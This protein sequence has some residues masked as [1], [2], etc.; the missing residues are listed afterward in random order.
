MK[1]DLGSNRRLITRIKV[2]EEKVNELKKKLITYAELIQ[3]MVERSI[4]G[5]SDKN[6]ALLKQVIE[7]DEQRA[8]EHEIE[9]DEMCTTLIVT[10]QP[11]A[12][13]L[14]TILMI[15]KMNNDLERIGD[16]AVNISQSALRLIE[17]PLV[18]P[19]IDI[20]RM[21]D[22]AKQMINDAIT[23][24]INKDVQLAKRVCERD[25]LVDSLRNQIIRELITYMVSDPSTIERALHLLNISKNLE[26]IAD[27]STNICEDVI[28]LVEARVIKHHHEE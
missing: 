3:G 7:K 5:L 16:H 13:D 11:K 10:L 15:L 8:N 2:I 22:E 14:R 28:F 26:R 1:S 12:I 27:L 24:F 20:P 9:I 19:L 21:A 17:Q 23:S 25:N 4:K 6:E 18:K